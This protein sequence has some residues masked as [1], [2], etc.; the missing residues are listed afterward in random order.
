M[1]PIV[2]VV[3]TAAALGG[4]RPDVVQ[5]GDAAAEVDLPDPN[6]ITTQPD[7]DRPR[8]PAGQQ[9]PFEERFPPEVTCPARDDG[10]VVWT[11]SY[12]SAHL[13][14]DAPVATVPVRERDM[15]VVAEPD[16][17]TALA[18]DDGRSLW[19]QPLERGIGDPPW[20]ELFPLP[21]DDLLVRTTS[22]G[23]RSGGNV[24]VAHRLSTGEVRWEQA[25]SGWPM[26]SPW[27]DDQVVHL[28]S[29]GPTQHALLG[30]DAASGDPVEVREQVRAAVVDDRGTLTVEDGAVRSD[31]ARRG[32]PSWATDLEM[33]SDEW[34][35]L[36]ADRGTV[37]VSVGSSLLWLDRET[38]EELY[39]MEDD[40]YDDEGH[41]VDPEI[42]QRHWLSSGEVMTLRATDEP[43]TSHLTVERFGEQVLD[44]EVPSFGAHSLLRGWLAVP[45]PVAEHTELHDLTT[46]EMHTVDAVLP[47]L[48]S[49]DDRTA[50]TRGEG[51]VTSVDLATSA[52]R[53]IADTPSHPHHL[54]PDLVIWPGGILL[55]APG[56]PE[57]G[58]AD[59]VDHRVQR[60]SRS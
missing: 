12:R 3:A 51:G 22:S 27:V 41:L 7:D 20:H 5:A 26:G 31:G 15:V 16:R 17:L 44:R 29:A 45:D 6:E 46:G 50:L 19:E 18:M 28:M 48:W 14:R 37:H 55:V 10:C 42:E 24:I 23:G 32:G 59:L 2:A 30:F 39:R 9:I 36:T 33:P 38:G 47:H 43:A 58:S 4:T 8:I 34:A 57:G 49:Q 25:A 35:G 11:Y 1:L 53:W 21:D 13:R 52:I 40:A 60:G 56:L 54:D